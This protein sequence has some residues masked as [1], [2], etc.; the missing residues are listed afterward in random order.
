MF[1]KHPEHQLANLLFLS[2]G[3]VSFIFLS[4]ETALVITLVVSLLDPT[5]NQVF[6]LHVWLYLPP[7]HPTPALTVL[8]PLHR[9]FTG[10]LSLFFFI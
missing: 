9:P 1:I 10:P 2:V 4:S 3:L 7:A 8:V 6:P 5:S